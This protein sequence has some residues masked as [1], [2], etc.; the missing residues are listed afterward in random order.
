MRALSQNKAMSTVQTLLSPRPIAIPSTELAHGNI[1]A[2]MNIIQ[3]Y[4]LR[5]PD[6]AV[7]ILYRGQEISDLKELFKL[8]A[9]PD[10][11]AF[12]LE[13]GVPDGNRRDVPKLYRLLVEG[14]GPGYQP[15]ITKELFKVLNLF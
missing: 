13:V 7:R 2:W 12:E 14:A 4:R 11:G 10:H 1:E 6:H 5:H 8:S 15:F 3:S 9:E